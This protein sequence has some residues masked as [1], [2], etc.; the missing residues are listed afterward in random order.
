MLTFVRNSETMSLMKPKWMAERRECRQDAGAAGLV[1][2]PGSIGAKVEIL[3]LRE[4]ALFL[5]ISGIFSVFQAIQHI[6][7]YFIF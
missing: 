5:G 7:A 1:H 3:G 4:R 6:S 2:G